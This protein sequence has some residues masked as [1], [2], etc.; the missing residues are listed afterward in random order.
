MSPNGLQDYGN[1][2]T[3]RK[4]LRVADLCISTE[5]HQLLSS[6]ISLRYISSLIY[7]WKNG[8]RTGVRNFQTRSLRNAP[9]CRHFYVFDV[10]NNPNS[11]ANFH[12]DVLSWNFFKLRHHTLRLDIPQCW[13][14]RHTNNRPSIITALHIRFRV[15]NVLHVSAFYIKPSPGTGLKSTTEISTLKFHLNCK[16]ET[17][18]LFNQE[19]FRTLKSYLSYNSDSRA[20]WSLTKN[21]E[22]SITF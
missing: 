11:P 14:N 8:F 16:A 10:Y 21:T 5:F 12:T 20:W 19:C 22:T 17:S 18:V 6:K 7:D 9:L 3:R 13:A 4:I 1:C 15:Q 2:G